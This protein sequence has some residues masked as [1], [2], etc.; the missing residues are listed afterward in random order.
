MS[1]RSELKLY[2]R[3]SKS[4]LSEERR[5]PFLNTAWSLYYLGSDH[6]KIIN[7]C[8]VDVVP[9]SWLH[10]ELGDPVLNSERAHLRSLGFGRTRALLEQAAGHHY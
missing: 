6:A 7:H 10:S 3:V 4:K 1:V 8:C 9:H 5:L 2:V